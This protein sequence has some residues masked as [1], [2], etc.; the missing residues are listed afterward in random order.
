VL[1]DDYTNP[2]YPGVREAIE[3]LGLEGEGRGSLFVHRH[4]GARTE[5]SGTADYPS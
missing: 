3:T 5:T 1:F 4:V 2:D